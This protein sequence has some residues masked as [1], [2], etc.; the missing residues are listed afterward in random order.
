MARDGSSSYLESLFSLAG[1]TAV[2]TGGAT[3]IGRIIAES[4][5][6]AGAD[7]IIAS[8]KVQACEECAAA[9]NKLGASGSAVG[10]AGDRSFLP[11]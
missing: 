11:G 4:L 3:G 7:V 9:L 1:K 2:V 6:R 8:R 5:V 10:I